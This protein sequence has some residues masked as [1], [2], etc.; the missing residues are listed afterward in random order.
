[1]AV[2]LDSMSSSS[3]HIR[4]P[5]DL[6]IPPSIDLNSAE[7]PMHEE[8]MRSASFTALPV[9]ASSS[10]NPEKE[11][12]KRF[13][14][15]DLSLPSPTKGNNFDGALEV[16]NGNNEGQNRA[17]RVGR[18]K[19]LMAR[20][21]SWIQQVKS[22]QDRR[23][24]PERYN[25]MKA[26][27]P[28]VPPMPTPTRSKSKTRSATMISY[29]RRSWMSTTSRS[30]SP[31]KASSK[32]STRNSQ[33]DDYTPP[34][35]ISSSSPKRSS[36]VPYVKE[37]R[38]TDPS[39][40]TS[41]SPVR[42]AATFLQKKR[43]RSAIF[44][45]SLKSAESSLISINRLSPER[46]GSPQASSEKL[47]T[48]PK[49]IDMERSIESPRRRDELWSAFRAL[50][51]DFSKF[52]AKTIAMK[53]NVVRSSLLPFLKN[54]AHHPSNKTLRPEDLDRRISILNK[55]WTGILEM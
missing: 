6:S 38:K 44:P 19:S 17:E 27:V 32:G 1:M 11:L 16:P 10:Y 18:R 25:S 55:W 4:L 8:L 36:A 34:S 43:P 52:Q 47:P 41:K 26:E 5:S 31:N 40:R 50:E 22:S 29:A 48:I 9:L 28:A 33:E 35:S 24:S 49:G 46:R 23:D 3:P 7:T 20:P 21:K 45:S 37:P 53:T 54:C 2:A 30:P 39:S 42:K 15:D 13:S 51:T 14:V 12:V